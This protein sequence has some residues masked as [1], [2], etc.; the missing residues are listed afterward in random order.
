MFHYIRLF[1]MNRKLIVSEVNNGMTC[2]IS[3][4]FSELVSGSTIEDYSNAFEFACDLADQR[5]VPAVID[6]SVLLW[7]RTME[8]KV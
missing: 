6:P 3:V 2:G 7:K 4:T 5:Q 1:V 8:A